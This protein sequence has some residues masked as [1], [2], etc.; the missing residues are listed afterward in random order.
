[1]RCI[2]FIDLS[3]GYPCVIAFVPE[4]VPQH[5]PPG[6]ENALCHAGL[7]HCRGR[8]IAD[9]DLAGAIHQRPREL[10]EAVLSPV[11]DLGVDCSN[12]PLALLALRLG[13]LRFEVAIEPGLLKFRPVR[14]F[15]DG[16]QP[17]IDA[18]LSPPCALT[19]VDLT[20]EVAVPATTSILREVARLDPALGDPV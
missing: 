9:R 6:I 1:L 2:G 18:D 7:C 15:R 12:L 14:A 17:E 3:V 8:Y 10:V 5:R 13:K 4:V 16:L 20:D 19:A 11:C